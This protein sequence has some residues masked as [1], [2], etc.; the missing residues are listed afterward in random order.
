[1]KEAVFDGFK[2]ETFQFFK[3]LE[4]NNYKEWFDNHKSIYT[5]AVLKSLK[6]LVAYLSPTMQVIDPSFELRPHRVIS[7]IYRDVRFS[8]NKDPYKTCMWFTFQIPVPR[9]DWKDY[10]GYFMEIRG[11]EYTLGMGLLAPKKKVMDVF[12]EEVEYNAEEFKQIT[13]R[14]VLDRGFS[15][16]GEEYKRPI[17]NDL[18]EYY[19]PWIQRKGVWVGKTCLIGG[20][21]FS[22]NFAEKTKEDFLALEWLYN[23]MKGCIL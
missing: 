11:D 8:K 4:Q 1:M 14:T 3:D 18:T 22:Q 15:V 13:Q 12:R 10:P 6:L 17:T 19:Q 21:I 5:D 23:F 16:Q 20:E 7:R 9:D 2:P